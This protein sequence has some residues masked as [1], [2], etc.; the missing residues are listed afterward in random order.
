MLRRFWT[1][2]PTMAARTACPTPCGTWLE[3]PTCTPVQETSP[4]RL[5][6]ELMGHGGNSVPVLLHLSAAPLKASTARITSNW[7]L[8]SLCILRQW[9]CWRLITP[10]PSSRS[11]PAL[12]TPFPRTHPLMSGNNHPSLKTNTCSLIIF[13][14]HIVCK[15]LCYIVMGSAVQRRIRFQ[16]LTVR[17]VRFMFPWNRLTSLV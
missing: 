13:I 6:S 3:Y 16:I 8:R 7:A 14:I 15:A 4:R 2:V 12:T 5:C 9:R 11:W 10:E 1:S 17:N